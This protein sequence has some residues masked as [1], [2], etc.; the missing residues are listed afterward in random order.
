MDFIRKLFGRVTHDIDAI[1]APLNKIIADLEA[2]T[3]AHTRMS[4]Q[5]RSDANTF[6]ARSIYAA[7]QAQKAKVIAAKVFALVA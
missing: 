1:I 2:A 6:Q 5:H 4:E 3:Q 7:E